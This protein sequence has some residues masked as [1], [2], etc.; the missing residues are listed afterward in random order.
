MPLI[1]HLFFYFFLISV[2][3]RNL[4]PSNQNAVHWNT[5]T[6]SIIKMNVACSGN[7]D[8]CVF[9]RLTN[10]SSKT[11]NDLHF[12]ITKLSSQTICMYAYMHIHVY[13]YRYMYIEVYVC[14]YVL[15]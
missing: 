15:R 9:F 6:G 5:I 11:K 3:G 14:I 7:K 10:G 12:F 1:F 13:V 8:F 2:M 4:D